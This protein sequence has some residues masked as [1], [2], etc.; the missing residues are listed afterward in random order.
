M[1]DRIQRTNPVRV[2]RLDIYETLK[3]GEDESDDTE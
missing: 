3:R 1:L 2:E